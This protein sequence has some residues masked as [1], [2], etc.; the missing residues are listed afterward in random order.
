MNPKIV[1]PVHGDKK[2]IREHKRFAKSCGVEDVFSAQNGDV[3]LYQNGKSKWL[4]RF[5]R[6]LWESI[7]GAVYRLA[8][9]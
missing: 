1:L 2:F 9:N 3:C 4:S 8:R 6:K 5:R 7:A